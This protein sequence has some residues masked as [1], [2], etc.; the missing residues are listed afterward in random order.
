MQSTPH[1]AREQS[2]VLG[3]GSGGALTGFPRRGIGFQSESL[4]PPSDGQPWLISSFLSSLLMFYLAAISSSLPPA[5][6]AT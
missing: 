1:A 2:S 5:P 4:N 6:Q 3:A